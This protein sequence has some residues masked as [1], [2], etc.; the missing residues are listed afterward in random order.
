MKGKR[1][2]AA[3]VAAGAAM[4]LGVL[5]VS[6][7]NTT[8][9][10]TASDLESSKVAAQS[11]GKWFFYDDNLDV[12]NNSLGSFVSGPATPPAGVGSAQISTIGT[13]RP[14]L[15][16]Y[17]FSGTPLASITTL[18]YS[19]YNPS[20]GNGGAANRSGYL[21]F[22]V[23]FDGTDTWQRRMTF[24]PRNNG[25]VIQNTWQE[26]DAIAGGAALWTYSGPT[27]PGTLTSGFTPRTW[28]DILTSYPGVR[29]RVTDSFVG[30]RVGEPYPDG[31]TENI[32][33]FKF[34]TAAGTTT[35]DFEP[36]RVA[37]N[38]DQCKDGGWQTVKRTDGSSFKNQGD[39]V[40]YVNTGK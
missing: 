37:T 25:T 28:N 34:G 21:Q 9:V 1:L 35:F 32:D 31:Y 26:W 14:N 39:C 38:T 4:L 30:I 8:V 7:A 24:V 33:A 36:Y 19:T 5:N 27:W 10:V 12:I 11:N 2:F 3:G 13:G 15:A 23:D 20:A 18:K 29:I 22:N 16:T 17:R 6:A 40:Q